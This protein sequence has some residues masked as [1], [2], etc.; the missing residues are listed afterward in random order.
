MEN[1]GHSTVRFGDRADGRTVSETVLQAVASVEGVEPHELDP[2]LYEA[3]DPDA[4]E[5]VFDG[6]AEG[7][8]AVAFE[9]QGYRVQVADGGAVTVAEQPRAGD[10]AWSQDG[11]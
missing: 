6:R 1:E 8:V 2:P 7:A 10:A 3:I 4:L 11:R 9:Y 5:R